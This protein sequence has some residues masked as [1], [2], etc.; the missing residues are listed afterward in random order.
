MAFYQIYIDVLSFPH[1]NYRFN[2]GMYLILINFYSMEWSGEHTFL[3]IPW[4][5]IGRSI[6]SISFY[7]LP[8]SLVIVFRPSDPYQTTIPYMSWLSPY[9]RM[10][11]SSLL[12]QTFRIARPFLIFFHTLVRC[13]GK[14]VV[15][16]N[17]SYSSHEILLRRPNIAFLP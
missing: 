3:S 9:L 13:R 14:F 17:L 7:S 6:I 1:S 5:Q 16:L 10:I 15:C 4:Y 11:F 12:R 2:H 8:K